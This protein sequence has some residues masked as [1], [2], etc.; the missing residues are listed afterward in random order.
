M[1]YAVDHRNMAAAARSVGI[2][3]PAPAVAMIASSP[4][5]TSA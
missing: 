3:C 4:R 2:L 1:D 5:A